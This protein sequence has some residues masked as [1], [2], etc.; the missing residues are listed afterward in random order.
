MRECV[1][2]YVFSVLFFPIFVGSKTNMPTNLP[3]YMQSFPLGFCFSI[4]SYQ[5]C[6]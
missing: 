3:Y 5:I 1:Y 4:L 6:H 2:M